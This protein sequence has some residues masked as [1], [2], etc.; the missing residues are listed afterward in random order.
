[1]ICKNDGWLNGI[2]EWMGE[3]V[4]GH[5]NGVHPWMEGLH[6]WLDDWRGRWIACMPGW[7]G[8]TYGWIGEE[9]SEKELGMSSAIITEMHLLFPSLL[10]CSLFTVESL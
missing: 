7:M 6:G 4:D 10:E 2:N 9:I 5:R 3:R 1:M 8:D